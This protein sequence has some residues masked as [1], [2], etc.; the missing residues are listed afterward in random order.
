MDEQEHPENDQKEKKTLEK[1][2]H[3]GKIKE[4]LCKLQSF[5]AF[6][7]IQNEVQKAVKKAKR[8]L[9]RS[10]AK[11][12]KKNPKAFYSYMKKKISNKVTVGPLKTSDGN[13]V[14][15]DKEMA[16][17]LN[18][19]YCDM[20]TREDHANMPS[21]EQLYNGDD[22]LYSVSFTKEK[23]SAKLKKLKPSSAFGP[24]RVWPRILHDL[25]EDLAEPLAL[26]YSRLLKDRAVPEVWLKSLVCPI[27]KKGAKR[28]R[29]LGMGEGLAYWREAAECSAQW[30]A[31]KLGRHSVW[32][33]PRKLSGSCTVLDLHQ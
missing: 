12:S 24:D 32:S 16:D 22:P 5:Q 15:E 28:W 10:L 6:K 3:R 13:L 8:K 17:I 7:N 11:N 27:F 33:D 30:S 18:R 26:I 9:E 21:V 19:H 29:H 25:A 23:V 1:L 31:V 14:T 2:Q 20:F 4:R